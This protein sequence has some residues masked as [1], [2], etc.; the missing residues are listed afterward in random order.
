M[1]RTTG[2]N[3]APNLGSWCLMLAHLMKHRLIALRL[4]RVRDGIRQYMMS[5]RQSK[6]DKRTT[7]NP[8]ELYF[9]KV[10]LS[11]GNM[12]APPQPLIKEG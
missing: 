6:G 2:I 10:K 5:W 4:A 11:S 1:N 7:K 8:I 9:F 3:L 12:Q